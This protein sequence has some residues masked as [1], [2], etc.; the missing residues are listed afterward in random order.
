[1]E[2]FIKKVNSLIKYED[3]IHNKHYIDDAMAFLNQS[4]PYI[5][6]MAYCQGPVATKADII[7]ATNG[8]EL[9]INP[10]KVLEK[11]KESNIQGR[12][13]G[14][15]RDVFTYVII[16]E[17]IHCLYKHFNRQGDRDTW[18]WNVAC[19]IR[20]GE[21]LKKF[22][23]IVNKVFTS[24]SIILLQALNVDEL[25]FDYKNMSSEQI[26]SNLLKSPNL[27]EYTNTVNPIIG[28]ERGKMSPDAIEEA[29]DSEIDINNYVDK[30]SKHTTNTTDDVKVQNGV[31]ETKQLD[32]D[33]NSKC[34]R[35]GNIPK[36]IVRK[37]LE[38]NRDKSLTWE[39]ILER[40]FTSPS[41]DN[42]WVVR[43]RRFQNVFLPEPYLDP[44]P[45]KLVIGIDTSGS[46]DKNMLQSFI[47]N[48]EYIGDKTRK[49]DVD[50]LVCDYTLHT[51]KKLKNFDS[52]KDL[53][54]GGGTSFEPVFDYVNKHILRTDC[55]IYFT[56]TIGIFPRK[57]PR[58]DVIWAIPEGVTSQVPVPWGKSMIVF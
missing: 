51:V 18:L 25:T 11:Y 37:I 22:A 28:G 31:Q 30:I 10:D 52:K 47:N 57:R 29:K 54:G 4:F 41:I 48:V 17:V 5:Y 13:Y 35:F 14:T 19:D 15:A 32:E 56:D 50:I 6:G 58:Y 16:H 42:G 12:F 2:Q 1:M 33:F 46:I 21:D 34:D 39:K 38:A 55:L 45:D 43:D 36:D 7:A 3:I 26:Y 20:I 44:M 27:F 9:F 24:I 40:L 23:P 8:K 49:Y 53:I